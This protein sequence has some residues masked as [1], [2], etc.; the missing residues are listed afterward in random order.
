MRID[1]LV[2]YDVNTLDAAG[3]KR[4]K[5]VAKACEGRG[6][7]VQFS[8]FECS[9]NEVDLERFRD[10]L[11]GIINAEEDSL[12]I[13]RLRGGRDE[14]VECYGRNTYTSFDDPLIV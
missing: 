12:R 7:R 13:Y 8:V 3:R 9:L 6:Q 10:K 14:C 1:I 5:K 4:L 11:L 2:S